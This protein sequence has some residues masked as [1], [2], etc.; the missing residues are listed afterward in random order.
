MHMGSEA[1]KVR[2]VVIVDDSRAAQAILEAAFERQRE[3]KVVGVASNADDGARLIR[4]LGPDLVTVDL[5]MP[6][7]NGSAFLEMIRGTHATCKIVVSENLSSN[8]ALVPKLEA[9]GASLCLRKSDV[10]VDPSLFFKKIVAACDQFEAAARE[11]SWLELSSD[12]SRRSGVR[13]ARPLIDMGL[14][15]P[16]DEEARIRH[17]E[18]K[19]LADAVRE[20]QFDLITRHMA[21]VS[22]FPVCLLNFIDRDTQWTKAAYG[23]PLESMPRVHAFCSHT[24]ADGKTLIVQNA[25]IDRRFRTNPIVTGEPGVR[26]YVGHPIQAADGTRL[27]ALC[28]IDTTVR[29]VGISV[30]RHLERVAGIVGAIIEERAPLAALPSQA[31]RLPLAPSAQHSGGSPRHLLA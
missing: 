26:T 7:I 1:R 24:I 5:C 14:P 31:A 21:E 2:R 20:Q 10:T 6:Y 17:V 28:L 4:Q 8:A 3:F 29:P 30:T 22:R 27:G 25:A 16:A 15:I 23:Y 12:S 11:Q 19:R 13:L 9:L 18:M